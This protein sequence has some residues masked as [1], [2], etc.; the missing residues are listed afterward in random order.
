MEHG[1]NPWPTAT[2][3]DDAVRLT[4]VGDEIDGDAR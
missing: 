2:R 4:L 1:A 3:D